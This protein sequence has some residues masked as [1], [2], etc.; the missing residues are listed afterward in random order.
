MSQEAVRARVEVRS[1]SVEDRNRAIDVTLAS[2]MAEARRVSLAKGDIKPQ[3]GSVDDMKDAFWQVA[4]FQGGKNKE[5]KSN[6]VYIDRSESGS[7]LETPQL[8]FRNDGG[9]VVLGIVQD[10]QS[11]SPGESAVNII[12]ITDM[13]DE[14]DYVVQLKGCDVPTVIMARQDFLLI[15]ADTHRRTLTDGLPQDQLALVNQTLDHLHGK[16]DIPQSDT[17]EKAA[18]LAPTIKKFDSGSRLISSLQEQRARALRTTIETTR[19]TTTKGAD[20]QEIVTEDAKSEGD[21]Q[22]EIEALLANDN[23]EVGRLVKRLTT[24]E[25]QSADDLERVFELINSDMID[26]QVNELNEKLAEANRGYDTANARYQSS[27]D[28]LKDQFSDEMKRWQSIR[29]ATTQELDKMKKLRERKG[30]V[31]R[32]FFQKAQGGE[33]SRE[34]VDKAHKAMQDGD[35]DTLIHIMAENSGIDLSN[36]NLKGMFENDPKKKELLTKL[37]EIGGPILYLVLQMLIDEM[38]RQ[39]R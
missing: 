23:D 38:R 15:F 26:K 21:I 28:G 10:E 35:T 36:P 1:N 17:I 13:T 11:L 4:T 6:V 5:G 9:E 22:K 8:T 31:S 30:D 3:E 12:K 33:L 19:K 20:G 37:L 16:A 39:S 34:I 29:Q 14:G 7:V 2:I 18:S 24:G 32:M 27:P 25:V